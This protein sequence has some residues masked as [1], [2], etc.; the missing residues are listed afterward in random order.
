[1][2]RVAAADGLPGEAFG[3]LRR[4]VPGFGGGH[5]F[6]GAHAEHGQREVVRAW[7]VGRG[8]DGE[9]FHPCVE[10]AEVGQEFPDWRK[11]AGMESR[12]D[13][14][15]V[16]RGVRIGGDDGLAHVADL[17]GG[18]GDGGGE[19]VG[20]PRAPGVVADV[21]VGVG[22]VDET[23]GIAGE[24]GGGVEVAVAE[25]V[26]GEAAGIAGGVG[27]EVSGELRPCRENRNR[28]EKQQRQENGND[29]GQ[30]VAILRN[31]G[32]R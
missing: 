26:V 30:C 15:R 32:V 25:A 19:A 18:E 13:E 10:F 28:Q 8:G 22:P 9:A 27:E 24:E 31:R 3:I 11:A 6:R 14:F 1:M 7:R 23:G 2:L 20:V 12:A 17:G 4:K 16:K 29:A 5:E 21:V